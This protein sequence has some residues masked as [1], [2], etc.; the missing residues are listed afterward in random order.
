VTDKRQVRMFVE[1]SLGT[2]KMGWEKEELPLCSG[3]GK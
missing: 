3:M 2:A 1:M